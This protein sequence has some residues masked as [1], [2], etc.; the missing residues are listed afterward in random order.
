MPYKSPRIPEVLI[1]GA[2][3][4]MKIPHDPRPGLLA[5]LWLLQGLGRAAVLNEFAIHLCSKEV[6]Y[7]MNPSDR[8][9]GHIDPAK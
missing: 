7:L 6:V 3:S 5:K 4:R 1:M 9:L 2:L 8:I